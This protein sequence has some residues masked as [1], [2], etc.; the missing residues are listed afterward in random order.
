MSRHLS[1]IVPARNEATSIETA[2]RRA[3]T[4]PCVAEVIVV[5]GGSTDGTAKRAAAA[6]ARVLSHARPVSAGGGRGGQIARG[7]AAARG[8]VV[9]I[10]HADGQSV[11]PAT[12]S[13]DGLDRA[14]P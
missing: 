8:D 10:V 5:D 2:V 4:D 12:A 14:L 9:A 11:V 6:G 1:I 13:L 3:A 7:L